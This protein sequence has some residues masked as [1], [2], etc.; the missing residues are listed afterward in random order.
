MRLT[1]V[2]DSKALL[3]SLKLVLGGEEEI[4]VVGAYRSAEDALRNLKRSS[5]DVMLVGLGLPGMSGIELI[6]QARTEAPKLDVLVYSAL[7]NLKTVYAAFSAGAMG[8]IIKG[9]KPRELVEALLALY[10]GGAPMSPKIARMMITEFHDRING[11]SV[12]SQREMEVLAGMDRGLTYRNIAKN[13][14]ISPYTVRTH[15]RNIYE[16]LPAKSK[17]E[18]LRKA[19][20]N[21]ML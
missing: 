7:D 17:E 14:L 21:G 2:Q 3:E 19:R 11:E 1:I 18:A 13:L 15:I 6:K 10:D 9:S 4:T 5:P 8:Y 16:K 20:K 12:L